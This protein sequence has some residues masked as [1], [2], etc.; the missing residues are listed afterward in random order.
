MKKTLATVLLVLLTAATL[1]SAQDA[2]KLKIG[3]EGAYPPFSQIGTDGKLKGFVM[4]GNV[5][6]VGLLRKHMLEQTTFTL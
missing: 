4:V 6:N 3:V 2:K 5:D 1:V